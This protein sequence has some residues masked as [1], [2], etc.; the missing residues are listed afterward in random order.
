MYAIH[1]AMPIFQPSSIVHAVSTCS[2]RLGNAQCGLYGVFDSTKKCG[3][4]SSP[5]IWSAFMHAQ[6]IE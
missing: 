1:I 3:Y 4:V 6:I 5:F 2:E